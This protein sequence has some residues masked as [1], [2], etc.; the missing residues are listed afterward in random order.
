MATPA[1]CVIPFWVERRHAFRQLARQDLVEQQFKLGQRDRFGQEMERAL[2]HS[3][4]RVIINRTVTGQH[5]QFQI[6]GVIFEL[7]DQSVAAYAWQK[8]A[9]LFGRKCAFC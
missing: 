3:R 5:D 2:F 7:L 9:E 6:R 4:H 1:L 8:L